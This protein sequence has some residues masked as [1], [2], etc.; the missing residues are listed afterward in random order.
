MEDKNILER[1]HNIKHEL[2]AMWPYLPKHMAYRMARDVYYKNEHGSIDLETSNGGEE[3]N[4]ESSSQHQQ[5][6]G[7][8]AGLEESERIQGIGSEAQKEG[9]TQ[10]S[11]GGGDRETQGAD[12]SQSGDN[13]KENAP[14]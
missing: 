13:P 6:D 7:P 14:A 8:Q 5:F 2:L 11:T 10:T 1:I 9:N 12:P 3:A 4:P